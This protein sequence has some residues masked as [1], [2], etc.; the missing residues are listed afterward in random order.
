M[1]FFVRITAKE[2]SWSGKSAEGIVSFSVSRMKFLSF[3]RNF[4]IS[5]LFS[6]GCKE[7][8]EQQILPFAF[9]REDAFC[10]SSNCL[11]ARVSIAFSILSGTLTVFLNYTSAKSPCHIIR[12]SRVYLL[13]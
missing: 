9:T 7:Q 11:E 2:P 8:V 5:R 3:S 10:K 6:C 12:L 4:F 1:E 13:V